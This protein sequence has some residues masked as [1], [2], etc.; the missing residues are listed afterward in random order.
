MYSQLSVAQLFGRFSSTT[1]VYG[2]SLIV[3]RLGWILLLPLYW[4]RLTPA[5]YGV[6]GIAGAIQMFLAPVLGL[7]LY[8]SVQRFYH[9]WR[10]DSRRRHVAALWAIALGWSA[11]VTAALL[12]GGEFLFDRVIRQVPF[13]PYIALAVA[14]AF[15]A[16]FLQ[17]P[18]AILRTRQ[19]ALTFSLVNIASFITQAAITIALVLVFDQGVAGYLAGMAVN[20]AL[21]ALVSV[22]MMARET[23]L[24][25]S[26]RDAREPLR[27]GLPTVPLALL[28]GVS[29]MLDRYFLDK[30][31]GLAQ[32]GLYNVGNQF[33]NAFNMFNTMMKTSWMPFLYRVVAERDDG[34][35]ILSRFAVYYLTFLLVPALAVALLTKDL[36]VILG[37]SRFFGAYPFVPAFVLLYYIHAIAAAMGRGMDLAKKTALWPVVALVSLATAVAALAILVPAWGAPGAVAALICAALVR[38]ITQVALSFYYYPR[39]LQLGLLSRVWL[40]AAAVFACGYFAPWSQLWVSIAGKT[41]LLLVATAVF[42]RIVLGHAA[43]HAALRRLSLR[44]QAK[45]G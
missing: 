20:A 6:I 36:I 33:G 5:D 41:I 44:S 37:D 23:S 42:A 2:A 7:G 15:F 31:V 12:A 17:F 43:F 32:I 29:A 22:A 18:L 34:P 10:D 24:R 3:T 39:P 28:D 11:V 13:H 16:N 30:Y 27:Y 40:V 9:E 25:F 4:T 35:A 21:W 45:L 19:R 8:D 38:V 1:A 26:L 14:T